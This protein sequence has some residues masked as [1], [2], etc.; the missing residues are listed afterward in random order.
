M[1]F[2][3]GDTYIGMWKMDQMCDP[4]GLYKFKNGSEYIGSFKTCSKL[5]QNKYGM[6]EGHGTL[7]IPGVGT[8]EGIFKNNLALGPGIMKFEDASK[9]TIETNFNNESAMDLI[10]RFKLM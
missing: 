3:N 7:K 2:A 1:N 6:F 5:T 9:K 8:F 4:E 10:E